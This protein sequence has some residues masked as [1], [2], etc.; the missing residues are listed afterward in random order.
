MKNKK[1][2]Y[3]IG[4][5]DFYGFSEKA[6]PEN[7]NLD[8]SLIIAA[9]GGYA[10]LKELDIK[11]HILIGDFDSFSL[12]ADVPADIETIVLPKEKNDTDT[13][14]AVKIGLERGFGIF[15]I[16]GGT[17]GRFEHTLA[18]MQCLAYIAENGA[19]GFIYGEDFVVTVIKNGK[20]SFDSSYSG[21]VSVFAYS[22]EA[23]G[24][25]IKGLKYELDRVILT[26][27]TSLGVSNEFI[28]KTSTVSVENGVIIVVFPF[29]K[30][31]DKG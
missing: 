14:A 3:I 12:S 1:L 21:Y 22:E 15:H 18:N 11:P 4:A 6:R 2:C 8:L 9:D 29:Y 19:Q 20:I 10:R 16:Y 31:G 23:H 30:N 13:F 7:N 25:S 24:V 26:S 17:G 5:G 27:N 28:G